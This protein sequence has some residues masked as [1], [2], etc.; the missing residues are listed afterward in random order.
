LITDTM[1]AWVLRDRHVVLEKRS[2]PVPGPDDAVIRTTVASIC[3]ADIACL[4][5]DIA[6]INGVVLG[7]EAVGVVHAV[8]THVR[9][10]AVGQRVAA[11]SNTPCGQCSNCQRGNGGHCGDRPWGSYTAGVSRDGCLAEFFTVPRAER[12]LAAIPDRVDDTFA[13]CATDTLLSGTTGPEAAGVVMGGVVA[14]FGQG[15][16][17]LAATAGARLLGAGL[18]IAVKASAVNAE[19]SI[20]M[21]ADC[22][23]TLEE[24]DV[25][26]EI[27]ALTGGSGVDCAIEASG[28]VSTFPLSIACTRL[29]GV[30]S[31]LS[32]YVGPP[33]ASLPI[34]LADWGWGISDKT[35]LSTMQRASGERLGRLL[36]LIAGGRID[37][38]PL[39][40]YR[41]SFDQ[42]QNA[43]NDLAAR[44]P[45]L[46][47]PIITFDPHQ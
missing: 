35:I 23:L 42:V 29:G 31:V 19:R 11:T 8:G 26:G 6:A 43:F 3:S 32:S 27:R 21:G 22:V 34:P 1:N 5:G 10:F 20:A 15:H 44:K 17:G 2:I 41:Y 30:V 37:P 36:R 4:S 39:I 28:V 25:E 24:H 12:N 9:G 7:H 18:V 47:K 16:I 13:V 38:A 46:V 45:G 40:S 33:D 14:V